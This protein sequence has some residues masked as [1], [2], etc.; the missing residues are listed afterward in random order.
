MRANDDELSA[1]GICEIDNSLCR[2]S[3]FRNRLAVDSELRQRFTKPVLSRSPKVLDRS[4]WNAGDAM[5]KW[6]TCCRRTRQRECADVH[7][8]KK[9]KLRA[10]PLSFCCR[11][12]QRWH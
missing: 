8:V 9:M 5:K 7:D 3:R 11:G 6:E 10:T 2:K 1:R 4:K 12:F